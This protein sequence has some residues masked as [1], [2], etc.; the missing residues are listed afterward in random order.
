MRMTPRSDGL[1]RP[2]TTWAEVGQHQNA[3]LSHVLTHTGQ[4]IKLSFKETIADS[5]LLVMSYEQ[6]QWQLQE[7]SDRV[8]ALPWHVG[9]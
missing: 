5:K 9:V 3:A 2:S 6:G 8:Q 4:Q 1:H 7:H